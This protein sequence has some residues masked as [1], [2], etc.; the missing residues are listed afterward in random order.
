MSTAT[1]RPPEAPRSTANA[2]LVLT[3]VETTNRCGGHSQRRRC[4]PRPDAGPPQ[5]HQRM[6]PGPARRDER[7]RGRSGHGEAE[8]LSGRSTQRPAEREPARVPRSGG[9]SEDAD[10]PSAATACGDQGRARR[11]DGHRVECGDAAARGHRSEA[12]GR[13][14]RRPGG[15]ARRRHQRP[16]APADHGDG[17]AGCGGLICQGVGKRGQA[18][19]K[20]DRTPGGPAVAALRQW[21]EA[22]QPARHHSHQDRPDGG[23]RHEPPVVRHPR[24][25]DQR[26]VGGPDRRTEQLPERVVL[27]GQVTHREDHPRTAGRRDGALQGRSDHRRAG[28]GREYGGGQ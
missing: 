12:G 5:R 1:I 11:Q 27:F 2:P 20:E 19:R 25:C 26:P 18:R 28:R 3:A 24:W 10:L 16:G 9:A 23:S 15:E 4:R 14:Q 22:E 17:S 21:R 13:H 6:M 8:H 7:R